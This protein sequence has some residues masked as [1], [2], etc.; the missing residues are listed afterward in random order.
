MKIRLCSE[1]IKE[2]L[3][4]ATLEDDGHPCDYTYC[5]SQGPKYVFEFDTKPFEDFLR[6][7]GPYAK[8]RL[9]RLRKERG[10]I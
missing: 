2:N 3:S 5:K 7:F 8:T 6:V 10:D 1:H 4:H 9:D